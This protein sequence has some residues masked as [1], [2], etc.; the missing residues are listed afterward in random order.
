MQKAL[1]SLRVGEKGHVVD[2]IA[3]GELYRRLQDIGL[4]KG[5]QV[6]CVNISPLKDPAAYRISGAV[7]A[8]RK[9]DAGLV[10]VE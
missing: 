7:I 1:S 8:L 2:N 6:E 9:E 4:V 3:T 5:N 10:F